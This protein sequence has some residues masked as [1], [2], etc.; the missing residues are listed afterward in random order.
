MKKI[1]SDLAFEFLEEKGEATF[2]QIWKYVFDNKK[3][4][5]KDEE[6][7]KLLKEIEDEKVGEFYT[8]LTVDG[9]FIKIPDEKWALVKNYSIEKIKSLRASAV[10]N[11]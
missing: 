1:A 8:L 6:P 9:R 7:D 2:S 11:E 5:W 3:N 4:I 10:E